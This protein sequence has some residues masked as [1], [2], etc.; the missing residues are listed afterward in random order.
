MSDKIKKNISIYLFNGFFFIPLLTIAG[1]FFP[2]LL[3]SFT[4]LFSLIYI[5]PSFKN[6]FYINRKIDYFLVSFFILFIYILLNST[7]NFIIEKNFNFE[8]FDRFFSRSLFLFRF[9]LYPISIIYIV[10][11]FNFRIEKNNIFIFLLTIF[12][13]IFDTLFQYFYGKDIFGF[14]PMER[15]EIAIGRLSGPF[16]DELIPGSYLMRYFFITIFFLFFIFGSSRYFNTIFSTFLVI[17]LMTIF[18]TGERSVTLLTCFGVFIYFLVFKQQRLIILCG[19]I[20]LI[21][22]AYLALINNPVLKKRIVD[23][24]FYQFGISFEMKSNEDDIKTVFS[25]T[26]KTFLDSHYGAHWETAFEIWK[27]NKLIG[28]G[29]K[30]F[31]FE[32]SNKIYEKNLSKLKS[33]RCATHP[34]NTYFEVLSELGLIGLIFFCYLL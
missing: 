32:C 11:K 1:P 7:I 13:V 12:F 2:D 21:I 16:G 30:Q 33:I 28:I 18:L 17:C 23:H 19:S 5:F 15:D 27:R 6:I 9:I 24:T 22:I 8:S 29:L 3:I 31:R 26:G 10:K 25:R 20:I 4:V 14:M 34:H